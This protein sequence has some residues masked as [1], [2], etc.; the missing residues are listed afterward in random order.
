M[1]NVNLLT[2]TREML[3]RSPLSLAA[4][5]RQ[6]T[7]ITLSWLLKF[8]QGKIRNPGVLQ[9]QSLYDY[10][11]AW[12]RENGVPTPPLHGGTRPQEAA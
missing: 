11:R 3:Y 7:E 4:I 8:N 10:L 6:N 9:V 2:D 12:E 1:P 5:C